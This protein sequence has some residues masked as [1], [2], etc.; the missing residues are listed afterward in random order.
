MGQNSATPL[1]AQYPKCLRSSDVPVLDI[2]DGRSKRRLNFFPRFVE[3]MRQAC[4]KT[5]CLLGDEANVNRKR[6]RSFRYSP[7]G[8]R[9]SKNGTVT[10]TSPWTIQIC[11]RITEL[12]LGGIQ[13]QDAEVLMNALIPLLS[14]AWRAYNPVA[15]VLTQ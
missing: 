2:A 9:E 3:R 4:P 8:H 14:L 1:R 15:N 6:G 12:N 13:G 5:S 10:Q 11:E 7:I